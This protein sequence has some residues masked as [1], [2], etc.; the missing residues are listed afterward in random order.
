VCGKHCVNASSCSIA[1]LRRPPVLVCNVGIDCVCTYM[2]ELHTRC[3]LH[4]AVQH[5]IVF[6]RDNRKRQAVVASASRSA[7]LRGRLC[8]ITI[9]SIDYLSVRWAYCHQH[10]LHLCELVCPSC[11]LPVCKRV[12]T[13]VLLPEP[14]N[15]TL[16][17]ATPIGSILIAVW[18]QG[19]NGVA[20][21]KLEKRFGDNYRHTEAEGSKLLI[22]Y[23]LWNNTKR[24]F[25]SSQPASLSA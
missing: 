24:E 9:L 10:D 16:M 17:I 14:I 19:L 8:S 22:P 5:C 23:I 21:S 1:S 25:K 7:L 20:N 13:P 11:Q 6:V 18:V 2:K 12:Q 4:N 15:P 3:N